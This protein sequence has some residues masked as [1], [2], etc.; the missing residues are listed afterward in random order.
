MPPNSALAVLEDLAAH[1]YSILNSK[2]GSS[3]HRSLAM[4][5]IVEPKISTFGIKGTKPD[6]ASAAALAPMAFPDRPM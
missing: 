4:R 2:D 3:F 1:R 6:S 5:L